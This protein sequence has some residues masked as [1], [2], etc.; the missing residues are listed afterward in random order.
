MILYE[1]QQRNKEIT[2]AKILMVNKV[3]TPYKL[4]GRGPGNNKICIKSYEFYILSY[5]Y[6]ASP[7]SSCLLY[8]S[9]K[10]FPNIYCILPLHADV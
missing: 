9:V 7:E 3:T 1:V 5:G 10:I 4:L 8:Y 2:V 6:G